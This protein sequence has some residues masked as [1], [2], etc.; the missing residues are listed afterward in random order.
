M[1]SFFIFE[2]K[3]RKHPLFEDFIDELEKC[4]MQERL[5]KPCLKWLHVFQLHLKAKNPNKN[6]NFQRI[7]SLLNMK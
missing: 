3:Y 2:E 1:V 5:I 4:E 6:H 7:N